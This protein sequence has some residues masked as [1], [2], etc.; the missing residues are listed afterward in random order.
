MFIEDFDSPF[1]LK[2]RKKFDPTSTALPAASTSSMIFDE[3]IPLEP[4]AEGQSAGDITRTG[5]TSHQIG[6]AFTRELSTT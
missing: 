5:R 6:S 4:S 3:V 2:N 1:E